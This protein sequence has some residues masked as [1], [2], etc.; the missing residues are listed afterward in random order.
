MSE[1]KGHW[2]SVYESKGEQQTSWFRPHLDESLRLVDG[3]A[4]D[5]ATP[6]ID[7]GGGR[8]NFVDDLLARGFSDL[9]VLDLSEAALA[10]A[11]TRLGRT[12]A[13]V[14][15]I[16]GDVLD[17]RLPEARYGLWHDRAVFHFLNEPADQA[18]Y[19]ALAA[20]S[21]RQGGALIIA[22]F[23]ADGPE[24]CSGLPV[25]RYDADALAARFAPAFVRIA[26]SRELHRTPFDNEQAFTYVL[27]RRTTIDPRA[28]HA[29]D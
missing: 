13:S 22:T 20:S 15:W 4:L 5:P 11:R 1:K 26:D 3:L 9:A 27:L 28:T 19:V 16:R 2:Q 14:Q 6:V 25:S 17:A 7:I 29:T 12:A 18:R 24:K 10:E 23:A 21:V 8:S